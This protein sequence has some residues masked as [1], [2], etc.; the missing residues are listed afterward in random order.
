MRKLLLKTMLLLCA[1]IVG[2]GTVWADEYE[3]VTSTPS[4]WSGEYLIVY[5]NSSTIGYVWTG[6]DANFNFETASITNSK[7]TKPSNAVSVTIS[8][9]TGGYSIMVN[10]GTN[11]GKYISGTSGSNTTVFGSSAVANTLT[12][13]SGVDIASNTSHFVFN[14]TSGTTRYRYYKSTTYSGSAY[15]KPQLYK[16]VEATTSYTITAQSN[17][18]DYGI[19]SLSGSVITGSPN[20]GYRYATPAYTVSPA[21]SAT[22]AQD[23][24][25]F[26]VTPSANTTVTIN[27]ESIPT[28]TATFSVN[29]TIDNN[30]DCTVAEGE[31]ITFPSDP[32]DINGMS[33][34][35]WTTA[36]ISG[37]A[38][39]A[40]TPLATSATMGN[41]NVTYYAVFANVTPGTETTK[42]DVLGS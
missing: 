39:T 24:N 2:S 16:K 25:A 13:S 8:S 20:S 28:H 12:Y 3:K 5:E 40:P 38:D 35:G 17:N 33:F 36:T 7:I 1:L 31:D 26:T 37:T 32:E 22:V 19:V 27:F 23:G 21:N 6:V 11:N 9:M 41:S 42:T 14:S 29:G 4:D 15:K 18:T 10:G 30:N 34:V